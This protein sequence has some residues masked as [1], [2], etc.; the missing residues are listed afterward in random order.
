MA[1]KTQTTTYNLDK[2][3]TV[4]GHT[5]NI[6]AVKS[7]KAISADRAEKAGELEHYLKIVAYGDET[8]TDP[9]STQEF[10]GAANCVVPIVPASGGTFIGPVNFDTHALQ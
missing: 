5:Y 6:N 10:T 3:L 8:S 1:K 9:S 2:T 7:D 4:D